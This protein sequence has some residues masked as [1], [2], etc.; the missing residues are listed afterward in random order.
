MAYEYDCEVVRNAVWAHLWAD[1]VR[2]EW[3][4][5]CTVQS[6]CNFIYLLFRHMHNGIE[7]AFFQQAFPTSHHLAWICCLR[8][9]FTIFENIYGAVQVDSSCNIPSGH[10]DQHLNYVISTVYDFFRWK[11]TVVSSTFLRWCMRSAYGS[12]LVSSLVNEYPLQIWTS[13]IT[14]DCRRN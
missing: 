2:T 7:L 13:V 1:A 12:S 5:F 11:P 10:Q 6:R 14:A 3:K 9:I 8:F 4:C